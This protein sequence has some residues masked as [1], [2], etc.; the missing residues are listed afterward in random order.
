MA[1]DHERDLKRLRAIQ[2]GYNL[3]PYR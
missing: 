2:A 1:K 3:D